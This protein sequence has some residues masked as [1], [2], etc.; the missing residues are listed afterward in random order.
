M[1]EQRTQ[2]ILERIPQDTPIL[3]VE[4]G[5]YLAE[6]TVALLK[7]RPLLTLICVDMWLPYPANYKCPDHP[8]CKHTEW[9]KSCSTAFSRLRKYGERA[10]ILMMESGTAATITPDA[11]VDF[12]FIDGAHAEPYITRD[13]EVWQSKVKPGGWFGGHDYR[14]KFTDVRAA[15]DRAAVEYTWK[16]E[17]GLDATWF[18]GL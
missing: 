2:A 15:V 7:Q 17:F 3:G 18:A 13:I 4:V 6:N 10:R 16:V 11:S 14:E 12:V 8:M 1:I 5:V 9:A